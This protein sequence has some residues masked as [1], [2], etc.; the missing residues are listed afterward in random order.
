[1]T[2]SISQARAMLL[3]AQGLLEPPVGAATRQDILKT[4]RSMG[5]LQIDTIHVVARSPY[6][7]LWS[8]L[9]VYPQRWLEE[10]ETAAQLFEY[11]AHAACF[12]PIEDFSLYRRAMLDGVKGWTN[13]EGWLSEHAQVVELVMNRIREGGPVKSSDFEGAKSP[14][15][16]W[17]WKEEKTALEV[18]LTRGVLMV[19]GRHNF[20]R[21]YDLR[22]RI[23]PDWDDT[24][25][26]SAGEVR[27]AFLLKTA[28]CLGIMRG[29]WAADYF[30]LYKT[31]INRELEALA[32]EGALL[33]DT[34]EGWQ[35]PVY[36]HP[37]R[38]EL[39]EQ[40]RRD[41]LAPTVTTL[42]SPFD[43]VVWDRKRA[44]ELFNFDYNIECY[45]PAAKRR[46]GYFTLPILQRGKLV[47]RLDP[48]AHR[49]QGRFE[50]RNLVL[51]PGVEPGAQLVG[52]LANALQACAAWH[53]T[54]K[55][56]IV[57]TTPPEL[58]EMIVKNIA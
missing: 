22:E 39:L 3:A 6:L 36:V 28:Y 45:T 13:P 41:E 11:W 42:L 34:V 47:G 51:E 53:A 35:D 29:G 16:W 31:G 10:P 52:D 18:L 4:I 48:K 27:R 24:R 40:A 46:Y 21:I 43:P 23:M 7:V 37:E 12:I 54:P 50:V 19:R 44:R 26:L 1:M 8:R 25:L 2:I 58:G 20:Q 49:Q 17:N 55:V 5:V 14:G 9:G 32:K 30:R 57:K 56:E 15:G 33:T 38:S